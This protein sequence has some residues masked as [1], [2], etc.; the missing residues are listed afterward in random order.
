[1]SSP[2][3]YSSSSMSWTLPVPSS[4]IQGSTVTTRCNRQCLSFW[5][6]VTVLAVADRSRYMISFYVC[7]C[8]SPLLCNPTGNHSNK[9]HWYSCLFL[10]VSSH[11]LPFTSSPLSGFLS[12]H[13][14]H[15]LSWYT[16]SGHK[17]NSLL[18][19]LVVSLS[20]LHTCEGTSSPPLHM[21]APFIHLITPDASGPK[22][23]NLKVMCSQFRS[24]TLN[25]IQHAMDPCR[26]CSQILVLRHW[27]T[28]R[29]QERLGARLI[30]VLCIT[31]TIKLILSCKPSKNIKPNE[32]IA[33]STA[34]QHQNFWV[35]L[36][37]LNTLTQCTTFWRLKHKLLCT[38]FLT[39]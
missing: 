2:Y 35:L 6:K 24:L 33:I 19:T 23:I 30:H 13:Q 15:M 31:E 9:P 22:C 11:V 14:N 32:A 1:M 26:R 10:Y 25:F 3:M 29:V 12:W 7:C 20:P 34:I 16:T 8:C 21:H 28:A 38:H 5:T 18:R 39:D 17:N 4:S 36:R 37:L 27:T